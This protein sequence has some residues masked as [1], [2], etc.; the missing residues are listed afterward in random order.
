M[1][2]CGCEEQAAALESATMDRRRRVLWAVL[3]I[4]LVMFVGELAAAL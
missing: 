3:A 2:G 4:N 1:P